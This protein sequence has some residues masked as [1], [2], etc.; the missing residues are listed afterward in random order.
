MDDPFRTPSV[1][2]T[3]LAKSDDIAQDLRERLAAASLV[4][5]HYRDGSLS[6]WG[7][8]GEADISQT[9]IRDYIRDRLSWRRLSWWSRLWA[10]T[11]FGDYYRTREKIVSFDRRLASL[12]VERE[13][14]MEHEAIVKRV[15]GAQ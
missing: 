7:C 9:A 14:Q 13:L 8:D 10:H 4:P 15:T 2:E 3:Q 5:V 6:G 1:P 11:P 12:A